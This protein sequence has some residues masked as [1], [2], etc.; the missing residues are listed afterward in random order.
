MSPPKSPLNT[1]DH[2]PVATYGV[3][4]VAS[5]GVA[6]PV[7]G[8][9]GGGSGGTQAV[10]TVSCHTGAYGV[11]LVVPMPCTVFKVPRFGSGSG[12]CQDRMALN[13]EVCRGRNA[14]IT[15]GGVSFAVSVGNG[16][17]GCHARMAL[18]C[19]V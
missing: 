8:C 15:V 19:E 13:C 14:G 17:G 6:L 11:P 7:C 12:G 3:S 4:I 16:S 5:S 18:N 9:V 10:R 2:G 1:L